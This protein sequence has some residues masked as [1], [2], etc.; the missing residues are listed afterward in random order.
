VLATLQVWQAS[1]S[2]LRQRAMQTLI[3]AQH[4]SYPALMPDKLKEMAK[5]GA[6]D[7]EVELMKALLLH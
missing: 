7:K 2:I 3:A 6:L 4:C 1:S 5:S